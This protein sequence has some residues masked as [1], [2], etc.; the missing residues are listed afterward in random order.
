MWKNKRVKILNAIEVDIDAD[1]GKVVDDDLT[2]G[3]GNKSIRPTTL[4]VEGRQSCGIKEF[5]LGNKIPAG[6]ILE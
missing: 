5:L 1:P 2:I 4:K 6:S 3:C